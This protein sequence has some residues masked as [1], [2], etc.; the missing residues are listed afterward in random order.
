MFVQLF[1]SMVAAVLVSLA[2]HAVAAEHKSAFT[3]DAF[4]AA[5]ANNDVVLVDVFAPWCPTCKKQ[6]KVIDAYFAEHP[7]SKVKV[8]VVDFDNQKEWVSYFKAP[9]QSTLL[10]YKGEEQLWFAVSETNKKKIFA[11]LASAEAR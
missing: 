5:Q 11:A 9:R 4:R 6:S 1:K 8:M 7:D 3:E 2:S 10:V